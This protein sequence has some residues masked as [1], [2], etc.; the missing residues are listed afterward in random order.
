MEG[1]RSMSKHA[2]PDPPPPPG[3]QAKPKS[4]LPSGR[5]GFDDRG[6]AVWEWRTD[7]GAYKTDV[8]TQKVRAIQE[9]TS[10]SLSLE[11]E[12]PTTGRPGGH[13]PYSS[14]TEPLRDPFRKGSA[15]P[16][17]APEEKKPQRRTLDDMR[18]LSEEIK[19]QR[20]LKKPT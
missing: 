13:D 20:A 15:P 4:Q 2:K 11:D 19:R 16:A 5:I 18:R 1:R 12:R 17:P 8:D 9:S 7:N 6:N 14:A 10:H 3:K